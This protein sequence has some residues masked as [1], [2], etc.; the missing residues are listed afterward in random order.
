MGMT[1]LLFGLGLLAA[2][3]HAE[4][5]LD[6]AALLSRYPAGAVPD[7]DDV[8]TAIDALASNDHGDALGVLRSLRTHEAGAVK[9]HAEEAEALVASRALADMRG[10][11][12]RQ[13]PS[14][15]DLRSWLGRH[16]EL[17]ADVA[18][19]EKRVIAYAALA[20][21]GAAW[22]GDSVGALTPEQSATA[23]EKAEALEL[24][25]RMGSA[26]PLYVDAALSGEAR[27]VHALMARGVDMERLALG[28]SSQ[29]GA[30]AG[31]PR[32]ESVP[33][34]HS[35]DPSTVSVLIGRAEGEASLPRLAA[36]ENLGLL[37]RAGDLDADQVRR[38]RRAL[39]LAARDTRP[40]IRHTAQ[41]ALAQTS[42]P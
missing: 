30:Q 1:A 32:L 11:A 7:T 5:S 19:T 37:L 35:A 38:A 12:A 8:H 16:P 31:L 20:T 22:S 9:A 6:P 17:G 23:V 33:V 10:D 2:Q 36:L 42:L 41:S 18:P 34:V 39:M 15:R 26:L 13:A 14:E 29:H 40:A 21:K 4:P 24:A 27:A 25:G 3:A 28:L